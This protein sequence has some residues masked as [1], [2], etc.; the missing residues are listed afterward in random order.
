MRIAAVV[1]AHGDAP[2]L[3]TTLDS[4][5]GQSRTPDSR[6]AVCDATS[7][8]VDAL[9]RTHGFDVHRAT[10]SSRD[11]TT[12]IAHNVT[13]GVHEVKDF[14]LAVLG[15]HD[16]IWHI[17]RVGHHEAVART[18]PDAV[19]LASDGRLIETRGTPLG[20]TLRDAFPVPAGWN[21][22]DLRK[23]WTY[24]LRHSVATGGAS[25]V[26]PGRVLRKPIPQGWLHDRWWSLL[27]VRDH[28]M[29]IDDVPVIDSRVSE[30][31]HVGLSDGSQRIP[32][33]WWSRKLAELPRS[34]I[35][36]GDISR[37]LL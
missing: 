3:V 11:V 21:N 36:V 5:T 18:F 1:V 33:A 16:D 20:G 35:R 31:Q 24:V 34:L 26:V 23:Q 29:V 9:L 32:R 12:R 22:L 15:D 27:A 6:I 8:Q 37:L 30:G 2:F 7:P 13:Q 14:D 17:D 28:G 10:T 19:M 4:I 25:A